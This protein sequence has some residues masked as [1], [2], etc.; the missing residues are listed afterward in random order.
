MV[1]EESMLSARL[2]ASRARSSLVAATVK[3]GSNWA[4]RHSSAVL[5]GRVKRSALVHTVLYRPLVD[6]PLVAEEDATY[7]RERL[8][9]EM[10]RLEEMIGLD[11]RTR[12]KWPS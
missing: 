9:P 7:I 11:L 4:R 2:P 6:K 5:V 8:L 1:L 12:W 10:V 3:Q